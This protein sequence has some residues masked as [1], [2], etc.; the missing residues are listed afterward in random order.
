MSKRGGKTTP[1]NASPPAEALPSLEEIHGSQLVP[2]DLVGPGRDLLSETQ[3]RLEEV[4]EQLRTEI[5]AHST[6]KAMARKW[7]AELKIFERADSGH[8]QRVQDLMMRLESESNKH[9]A[10][11]ERWLH[12]RKLIVAIEDLHWERART[13][14]PDVDGWVT[15]VQR[16]EA[17]IEPLVRQTRA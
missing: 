12:V 16:Y 13:Q 2:T 14:N 15:W 17:A 3:Q 8:E 7:E 1:P 4:N 11:A 9:E 10:E 6:T 5:D